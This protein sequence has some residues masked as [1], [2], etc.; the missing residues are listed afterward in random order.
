MC[1]S[2]APARAYGRRARFGDSMIATCKKEGSGAI[3]QGD[4]GDAEC[5]Q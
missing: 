4:H 5:K 2:G 3:F 1:N